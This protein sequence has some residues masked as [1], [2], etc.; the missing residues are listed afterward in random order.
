MTRLLPAGLLVLA[1]L[2]AGHRIVSADLW[3]H[4]AAGRWILEHGAIPREEIF[5]FTA[6]GHKWVDLH[7][8]YQLLVTAAHRIGGAVGIQL[9]HALAFLGTLMVLFREAVRR[10]AH[11]LAWAAPLLILC[12][13][14]ERVLNRPEL[15]SGLLLATTWVLSERMI[16]GA[17][18]HPAW[19]LLAVAWANVQGLFILGP[20]LLGLRAAG[21]VGDGLLGRWWPA[22]S[23]S[24]S[25]SLE[26][27]GE[28][29]APGAVRR[30]LI[31]AGLALVVSVVNPYGVEGVILPF[32]LAVQVGGQSV[33]SSI[34][35]EL[36]SPFEGRL[37]GELLVA[38]TAVAAVGA[39]SSPRRRL[40]DLVPVVAFAVLAYS[41]RRNLS[42]FAVVAMVPTMAWVTAA[43][44][45]V[46]DT[47]RRRIHLGGQLATGAALAWVIAMVIGGR[48]YHEYRSIKET[49]LGV[50]EREYPSGAA[51]WLRTHADGGEVFNTIGDGDYLLWHLGDGWRIAFDGR[52]E[53]Y[54][55]E[56]GRLL[57]AATENDDAF[58][59]VDRQHDLRF[60]VADTS[61]PLGRGFLQR[62]LADGDW[63]L[64]YLDG[65]SAVLA[66]ANVGD[67]DRGQV[68]P[69]MPH[70]MG[71]ADG[72]FTIPS[73]RPVR[74]W[75]V[76]VK[77][78]FE[79]ARLGRVQAQLGLGRA[80]AR[81]YE[82]AVHAFPRS[83]DL[84]AD[85]GAALLAIE[86]LAP[87]G[88]SFEA[89]LVLDDEHDASHGGL[90]RV[91]AAT[92]PA[93]AI[94]ALGAYCRTHPDARRSWTVLAQL[95]VAT[96]DVAGA[97]RTLLEIHRRIPAMA[98][99]R[100]GLL[101]R[102]GD[103]AEALRVLREHLRR[104]PRDADARRALVS[105][106]AST[107]TPE[108]SGR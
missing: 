70:G 90:A 79:D 46:P 14:Q 88:R 45:R 60:L 67:I 35:A 106:E 38:V 12:M 85:Y 65:R 26:A 103:R 63:T 20:I 100:A 48:F 68:D 102:M 86:A 18:V 83:A 4:L 25:A 107:S 17:R 57:L 42:L 1:L 96:G 105:L 72:P 97:R 51:R 54:G 71:A 5:S 78:P 73:P 24:A 108:R 89:A 34:L 15:V 31:A 80:A 75:S 50:S 95:Q 30:L 32:R 66:R 59:A 36:L 6:T 27:D 41:A 49:G 28:A 52:A 58:H 82:R 99:T 3:L 43:L 33:Y 74:P 69:E 61:Q 10:G 62:R 101:L 19:L 104:F 94:D 9:L 92:D 64:T 98:L 21:I 29:V 44:D 37:T 93:G 91:R 23:G 53:V 11:G 13:A 87:A 39:M 76:D 22:W 7:W 84:F 77:L 16:R 81:S 55:E 47:L 8:G 2:L 40:A 56:T